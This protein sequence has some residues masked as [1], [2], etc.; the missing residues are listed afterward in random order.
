[1]NEHFAINN[2]ND[3]S[4]YDEILFR[5]MNY[6]AVSGKDSFYSKESDKKILQS[7]S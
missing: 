7:I 2:R 1:M 6:Q 5:K 4:S 3:K